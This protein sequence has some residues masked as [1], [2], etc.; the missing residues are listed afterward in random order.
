[1][2][3]IRSA[4]CFI[5]KNLQDWASEMIYQ[6]HRGG[7]RVKTA[8]LGLST[9]YPREAKEYAAGPSPEG[10]ARLRKTIRTV[11]QEPPAH[12]ARAFFPDSHNEIRH[13]LARTGLYR[14]FLKTDQGPAGTFL[15]FVTAEDA[16]MRRYRIAYREGVAIP[17]VQLRDVLDTNP[18]LRRVADRLR[19]DFRDYRWDNCMQGLEEIAREVGYDRRSATVGRGLFF[20]CNASA[21][22]QPITI[23]GPICTKIEALVN[24]VLRRVEGKAAHAKALYRDGTPLNEALEFAE[25]VEPLPSVL[26]LQADVYVTLTGEVSIDQIQLPDVGLFLTEVDS[27]GHT[28]LPQVQRI[29]QELRAHTTELFG[30][31]PAP[32][33]LLTRPEVLH[34]M[35]DTLEHL[36]IQALLRMARE[37]DLDLR[38]GTASDVPSLPRGAQALLLNVNPLRPEWEPLL[39]RSA[40]DEIRCSPDPFLKLLAP[41]LTTQ[42][43]QPVRGAQLERFLNAIRPGAQMGPKSYHAMHGG[44]ERIYRHGR[45]A[46][47]ILHVEVPGEKSATPTLRH[48][49]HS[50]MSLFN[51][52]KRNGFPDL[53]IREVPMNWDNAVIESDTG[54]HISAFRFYFTRGS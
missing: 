18:T 15:P 31:I 28:I 41:E 38:V 35:E 49:V 45:Y 19:D 17:E 36:E 12:L 9:L 10:A 32:A 4:V 6:L 44:I 39:I 24:E 26:Y 52:C 21:A 22:E 29:V 11:Q 51:T 7:G 14:P 23:P 27:R 8:G 53:T 25:F 34:S 20:F 33:Y 40:R 16:E 54:P 46:S 2:L 13:K 1:M 3:K 43:R 50:F 47:D 5:Q 37:A 48:S 42:R 30:K